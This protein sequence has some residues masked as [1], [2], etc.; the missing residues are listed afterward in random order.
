MRR[1]RRRIYLALAGILRP[2]TVQGIKQFYVETLGCPKN[3]VD[4]DKV[5]ASLLADGEI[6]VNMTQQMGTHW[7]V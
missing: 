1:P 2:V 3:A 6:F 5:V 7:P 4:S